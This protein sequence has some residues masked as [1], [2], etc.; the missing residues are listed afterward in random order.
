MTAIQ[1]FILDG[2]TQIGEITAFE[3]IEAVENDL[4]R[5]NWSALLNHHHLS[6]NSLADKIRTA[7][8]LGLEI[9]DN[10][11]GWRY[12]GPATYRA[13]TYTQT[14]E[15]SRI[16][17]RG[18]DTMDYLDALLEWPGPENATRWWVTA[19]GQQPTSTAV[20]N[21]LQFQG[22]PFGLTERQI[23]NLVIIDPA[24]AFGQTRSWNATGLP[25][26]DLWRPWFLDTDHT[27]RLGLHRDTID[28]NHLRFTLGERAVAPM[29]V[30]PGL[31]GDVTIIEQAAT[32]TT[33]IA[34]GRATGN[35]LEPNEKFVVRLSAAE[36]HWLE[37]R[38]ERFI[39]S[40]SSDTAAL[41]TEV[42]AE[43]AANGPKRTV[44]VPDFEIPG[45]GDTTR[46][47]DYVR[48]HYDDDED[49]L[50]VPI[51]S[52]TL[53]GTPNGWQ[54]TVSVGREVTVGPRRIRSNYGDI[55]RRLRRLE[56][57]LR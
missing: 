38:R 15:P 10:D 26:L 27:F 48:V 34:M 57:Q 44:I 36:N 19:F 17:L 53:V 22:G 47:G 29:S 13:R 8:R 30:T 52:S 21:T 55:S 24:T 51:G 37:R 46:L 23:P 12:S 40:P 7:T 16:E 4:A 42:H 20:T 3:R 6:G 25:L 45:Y 39:N 35:A 18:V 43:L 41:A 28:G 54:R 9:V 49:E 31:Q 32:A 1:V 50:L 2:I 33:I 56:G 11:T 5:G 14:G